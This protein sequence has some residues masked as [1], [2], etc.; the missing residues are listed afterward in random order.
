MT[1]VVV[2]ALIFSFVLFFFLVRGKNQKGIIYKAGPPIR[3]FDNNWNEH[4]KKKEM[5]KKTQKIY[6]NS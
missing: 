3:L 6:M 5:K 4:V 1:V 2:A